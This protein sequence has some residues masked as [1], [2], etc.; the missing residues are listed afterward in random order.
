MPGDYAP[1]LAK[2][3]ATLEKKGAAMVYV[4]ESKSGMPKPGGGSESKEVRTNFYGV[5]T[6][7][8]AD[9]IETGIFSAEYAVIL[10]P[11]DCTAGRPDTTDFIEFDGKVWNI[12]SI[13]TVAPTELPI[14]YK[15]GVMEEGG[16]A[17]TKTA[18]AAKV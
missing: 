10:A 1:K 18:S 9:E 12:K 4:A 6:N 11:G 13:V 3:K 15:F 14:L 7:P 2:A 17:W 8:K 5:R 16:E